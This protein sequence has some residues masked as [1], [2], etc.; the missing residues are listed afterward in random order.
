MPGLERRERAGRRGGRRLFL[1]A[2]TAITP[3]RM[4]ASR[5][6]ASVARVIGR[7][8]AVQLHTSSG[9]RP[10]S[11][12]ASSKPLSPV[13]RLPTTR[14]TA[15]RG[16]ACGAKHHVGGS[17]R[18][19]A[20]T[21][22]DQPPVVPAGRLR[23]GQGRPAPVLPA[24]PRGP[25]PR[26]EARPPLRRQA[27]QDRVHVARLRAQP[28]RG[29]ARHGEDVGLRPVLQPSPPLPGVPLHTVAGA[30]RRGAAA[31]GGQ[32]VGLRASPPAD[33]ASAPRAS[34]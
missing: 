31:A 1:N 15:C 19:G 9:S 8:Q 3:A 26:P 34:L 2:S 4:T 29:L 20:E 13:Q 22:P 33:R 27:G 30:P 25:V 10:T 18:G 6:N 17:R 21:A 28:H 23:R 16:V 7:Y 11:S 5:A 32:T 12:V 24:R 14:T